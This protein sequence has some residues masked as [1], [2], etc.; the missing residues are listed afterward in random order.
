MLAYDLARI[1]QKQREWPQANADWIGYRGFAWP[2]LH[3]KRLL[4][5]IRLN[6]SIGVV[7][8]VRQV[9]PRRFAQKKAAF[10]QSEKRPR[11][12]KHRL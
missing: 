2:W 11:N 3:R 12:I 9:L 8:P 6:G 1:R 10:H 4:G 5:M 7:D